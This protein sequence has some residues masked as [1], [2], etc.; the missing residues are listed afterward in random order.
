MTERRL[1]YQEIGEVFNVSKQ[2][3]HQIL[4][5]YSTAPYHRGKGNLH[6]WRFLIGR[7]CEV[8]FTNSKI[9]I[10]HK[11][12]NRNNN[13]PDNLQSLCRKHHIEEE[14]KLVRKGIKKWNYSNR[15]LPSKSKICPICKK[16]FWVQPSKEKQGKGKFCSK[17]CSGISQRKPIKHGTIS[18]Y[19]RNCRCKE[20]KRVITL[21]WRNRKNK[22][23]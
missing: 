6:K 22:K 1:T 3:I 9:E 5:S 17:K 2:R 12:G 15:G 20:C 21:Y 18:G 16:D 4:K 13:K 10:H 7:P 23:I 14:K 8:C 19:Q 11:D